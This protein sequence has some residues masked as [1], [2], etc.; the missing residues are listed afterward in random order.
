MHSELLFFLLQPLIN[1]HHPFMQE[2]ANQAAKAGCD[3]R[4]VLTRYSSRDNPQADAE[5][6]GEAEKA[7][8]LKF[9]R[10][11]QVWYCVGSFLK[12][13]LMP[14]THVCY[15]LKIILLVCCPSPCIF[16]NTRKLC[17]QLI[18]CSCPPHISEFKKQH[19]FLISGV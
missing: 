17:R 14:S 13:T 16:C 3:A 19:F 5:T 4:A 12:H 7:T 6:M 15:S 18:H 9:A 1:H 2:V 8:A 10:L 11:M